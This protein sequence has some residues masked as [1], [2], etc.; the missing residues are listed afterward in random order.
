[1]LVTLYYIADVV[2]ALAFPVFFYVGYR[3]GRFNRRVW[4]LYWI[5]CL[6]GLTWEIPMFLASAEFNSEPFL[7]LVSD[8][9]LHPAMHPILHTLWDGGLFLIGYWLTIQLCKSPILQRFRWQELGVMVLWGQI[10]ELAVETS[11]TS[12]GAWTFA[13]K[14]YNPAL[15]SIG[16]RF[17]TTIPQTIWLA[18]PVV[19]YFVAL[20]LSEPRD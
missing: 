12:V 1:M 9:P 11:A 20:R 6:I 16:D 8:F 14:P 17:V 13:V 7:Y 19:F 5:G 15:F 4:K 10:S 2:I 3:T 18:A